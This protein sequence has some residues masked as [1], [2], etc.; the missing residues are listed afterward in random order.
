MPVWTLRKSRDL[1]LDG[2]S[3]HKPGPAAEQGRGC[4]NPL[5]LCWQENTEA[6]GGAPGADGGLRDF[7]VSRAGHTAA[8][9][10]WECGNFCGSCAEI[11][12]GL[13]WAGKPNPKILA[14]IDLFLLIHSIYK[15]QRKRVGIYSFFP[16]HSID[17]T[18][19]KIFCCHKTHRIFFCCS[20]SL[21]WGSNPQIIDWQVKAKQVMERGCQN[22]TLFLS[23][24]AEGARS[25]FPAL[26]NCGIVFSSFPGD[27]IWVLLLQDGCDTLLG[28]GSAP[29]SRDFPR[30]DPS[31][32]P[33][34]AAEELP[35]L[36]K[37][38]LRAGNPALCLSQRD[39]GIPLLLHPCCSCQTSPQPCASEGFGVCLQ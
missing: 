20:A 38:R 21:L 8:L 29:G 39:P 19:E 33:K 37:C 23:Q 17:K 27:R 30:M 7:S 1:L 5:I 2:F 18:Q 9:S 11:P 34:G 26:R 35:E 36:S 15:T 16:I 24:D 22:P 28:P 14:E 12:L 32:V 10:T 6:L 4:V 13:C 25:S 31:F 3:Q